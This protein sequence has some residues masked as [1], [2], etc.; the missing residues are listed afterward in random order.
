MT[1]LRG[2]RARTVLT[3]S[4]TWIK[5]RFP[6]RKSGRTVHWESQLERDLVY[7]LEFDP[8]VVEYAEQPETTTVEWQGRRRRYTP[9]FRVVRRDGVCMVEVKPLERALK[10]DVRAF[11]ERLADHYAERGLRFLVMTEREIRRQPWL[12]NVTLLLRYQRWN[13]PADVERAI[14]KA[15]AAQHCLPLGELAELLPGSDGLAHVYALI[16][17]RVLDAD[18]SKPLAPDT[19]IRRLGEA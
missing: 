6:S 14:S 13:V 11:L 7:L 19:P 15:L 4:L 17:R 3:P 10:P 9:D 1:H 16:C 12:A 8:A 5:G 2:S 18:L